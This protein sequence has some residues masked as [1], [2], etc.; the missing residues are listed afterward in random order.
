MNIQYLPHVVIYDNPEQNHIIGFR[1]DNFFDALNK[2]REL[3]ATGIDEGFLSVV[4]E[5][6]SRAKWLADN[7]TIF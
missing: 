2:R 1:F 5:T 6:D 3:V 7:K 4:L